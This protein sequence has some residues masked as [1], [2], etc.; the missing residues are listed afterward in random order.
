MADEY[1]NPKKPRQ[2]PLSLEALE[3]S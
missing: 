3:K 2:I 1:D